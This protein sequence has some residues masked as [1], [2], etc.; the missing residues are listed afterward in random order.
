MRRA[1]ADSAV[2]L[3]IWPIGWLKEGNGE[4][5]DDLALPV[6]IEAAAAKA[7][8]AAMVESARARVILP[9]RD[10]V[11]L[12]PMDLES[13][14]PERH[15]ARLVWAWVEQH[16]LSGLYAAIKVRQGGVGR[17]A[18]APE[19]LLALWLDATPEGVGSARQLSRLVLEHEAYN[20][21]G[22]GVQVNHRRRKRICFVLRNTRLSVRALRLKK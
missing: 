3:L 7:A 9:N 4:L 19:I 22:G 6:G 11:E 12:R 21:I 16:D 14:L 20:R 15:R 17:S 5:F 1:R 13:L 10:Q 8:T 18:I 2:A